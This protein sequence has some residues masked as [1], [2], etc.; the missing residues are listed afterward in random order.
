MSTHSALPPW[1]HLLQASLQENYATAKRPAHINYVQL[2][3]LDVKGQPSNRTV[4]FRGFAGEKAAHPSL[5]SFLDHQLITDDR[6]KRAQRRRLEGLGN[7]QSEL[8]VFTTHV[9]SDKVREI[10]KNPKAEICWYLP[11]TNEQFRLKGQMYLITSPTYYGHHIAEEQKYQAAYAYLQQ[12][13]HRTGVTPVTSPAATETVDPTHT[14][15]QPR[16]P[17]IDWELF[18]LNH[19][20]HTNPSLRSSFTWDYSGRAWADVPPQEQ[21]A[22][23]RQLTCQRLDLPEAADTTLADETSST[24]TNVAA[25]QRREAEDNM[26]SGAANAT[27]QRPSS[28]FTTQSSTYRL[29]QHA[30]ANFVLLAFKVDR[31]DHVTLDTIPPGRCQ[32]IRQLEGMNPPVT[33]PA[34]S[35]STLSTTATVAVVGEA[36]AGEQGREEEGVV[37]AATAEGLLKSPTV[38]ESTG[39]SELELVP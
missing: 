29:V 5:P 35:P 34:T 26:G 7:Y 22:A 36:F 28:S 31:V 16:M 18:R 15:T 4:I 12:F 8:L 3:T 13:C 32:F 23:K 30:L 33:N 25:K 20:F 27:D 19:F 37:E 10:E 24:T 6:E 11:E 9:K 39:W 2:A 17:D 14:A 21:D 38:T 1:K